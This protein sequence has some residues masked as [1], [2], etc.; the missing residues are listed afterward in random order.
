MKLSVGKQRAVD[1]LRNAG[2]PLRTSQILAAG[3]HQRDLYALRTAGAIERVSRGVYHLAELPALAEPDIMTVA[4]RIPKGVI[5]LVSAL[6][7]H[8]LTNEIPRRVSVAILRGTAQPKL[9]WPPIIVYRFSK[10]MFGAGI[11]GRT[12]QGIPFRVYGAAKS[13]A[14]CFRF[15]NRLGSEVAIE[16]LREGLSKRLFTPAELM[17][18]AEI[19]RVGRIVR[20]F[21]DAMQ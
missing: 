6:S 5:C 17:R 7:F 12:I 14:D 19:C 9:D 10:A 13:V 2:K 8:G 15:R 21:L 18:Y 1:L 3:V 16:S 11:E 4:S 20:P